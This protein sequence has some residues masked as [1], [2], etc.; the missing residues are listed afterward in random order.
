[1]QQFIFSLGPKY[2]LKLQQEF[3]ASRVLITME[4]HGDV[5]KAGG[6]GHNSI[7]K[8][9]SDIKDD[10]SI[11]TPSVRCRE[12]DCLRAYYYL[13]VLDFVRDGFPNG[14]QEEDIFDGM[15]NQVFTEPNGC[16]REFKTKELSSSVDPSCLNTPCV[17]TLIK[18]I[19]NSFGNISDHDQNG[20]VSSNNINSDKVTVCAGDLPIQSHT[21]NQKNLAQEY[22][23]QSYSVDP[24]I[25]PFSQKKTQ[26][27]LTAQQGRKSPSPTTPVKSPTDSIKSSKTS[28]TTTLHRQTSAQKGHLTNTNLLRLS[29]GILWDVQAKREALTETLGYIHRA[30]SQHLLTVGPAEEHKS[31]CAISPTTSSSSCKTST[32]G[33][34]LEEDGSCHQTRLSPSSLSPSTSDIL[35]TGKTPVRPTF[36]NTNTSN[37]SESTSPKDNH[38]NEK[39]KSSVSN[40]DS[41]RTRSLSPKSPNLNELSSRGTLRSKSDNSSLSPLSPSSAL[42]PCVTMQVEHNLL[43]HYDGN[44]VT[45]QKPTK[46]RS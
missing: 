35:N 16:V 24:P 41:E 19:H 26:L 45:F 12:L 2:L 34:G 30:I 6:E 22:S 11:S 39:S 43:G 3:N 32:D 17:E 25:V 9:L 10:S 40:S 23:A 28:P 42:D 27:P 29:K 33:R 8:F 18:N 4:S 13:A 36:F 21:C 37:N 5:N 38:S 44:Q 1:M 7:K 15:P 20:R 46:V 14:Q 31:S